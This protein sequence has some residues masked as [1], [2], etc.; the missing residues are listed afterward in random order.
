MET[1]SRYLGRIQECFPDLAI[2][3]VEGNTEGLVH[4]VVIINQERVFRFPKSEGTK[5]SLAKEARVLDLARARVSWRLSYASS[6][7][8]R[9]TS[10]RGAAFRN[11]TPYAVMRI[12]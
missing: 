11:P 8:S 2:S 12:G 3:R 9:C 6:T 4:D 7:P 1:T 5:K 10:S